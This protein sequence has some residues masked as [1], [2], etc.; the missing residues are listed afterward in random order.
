[1]YEKFYSYVI[2]T[3]LAIFLVSNIIASQTISET[4]FKLLNGDRGAVL[5][6]LTKIKVL[7]EYKNEL[8]KYQAEFPKIENDLFQEDMKREFL[9][10]NF[11]QIL[12]KNPKSRDI[13]YELHLLYRRIGDKE[14]ASD[15]LKRAKEVDPELN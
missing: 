10:K 15:Y 9:I 7:P 6:F 2:F 12:L 3:I 13:L 1:M 8:A 5:E 4:F 11:E 14:K